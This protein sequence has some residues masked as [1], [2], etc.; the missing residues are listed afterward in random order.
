[1]S[2]SH[3]RIKGMLDAINATG[4]S[5]QGYKRLAYTKEE[6]EVF[7]LVAK[8]CEY[9]GMKIRSDMAGN[10]IARLEGEEKDVPAIAMGSHL[11]TVYTGGAFDGT[12]GVVA[13]VEVV[14]RIRE[15]KA[16][17]RHPL[18]VI[19]FRAEESSRFGMA[20]IG[21]K[22]MAGKLDIETFRGL[23]DRDGIGVHEAVRHKGIVIERMNEAKRTEK[24]LAAFFEVH[25][26]QGP[27]L[28]AQRVS[29]AIATAVAA[30]VRLQVEIFGTYAHSGTTAMHRRQDAMA[31][32][33]EF[34]LTV[35]RAAKE[36]AHAG[37]VGTVGVLN[38][39]NGAMNVVPG[40]VSLKVDIRGIDQASIDRVVAVTENTAEE[41]MR[42][43]GVRI[44]SSVISSETP[45]PLSRSLN[46][47][48]EDVA[49][50]KAIRYLSIPS[51]AGHDAMNLAA[52]TES[53]LL[54]IP[55]KDGLSH[56]P[57]EH[58]DIEDMV[59]ACDVLEEAVTI[60]AGIQEKEMNER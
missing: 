27:E 34:V 20:T 35:E 32:A 30:P 31:A 53:A 24:D 9:Q 37:T 36:E 55:S 12:V 14:T 4:R 49:T 3:K 28:E 57:D 38:V 56:H 46:T 59:T 5:S 7:T 42:D 43:R 58:S 33:A 26:E 2:R 11:D 51:G 6:D 45:V 18:E 16:K 25:I 1:M 39:N 23:T 19:V 44:D 13:A 22:A 47:L 21:S 15:S 48:L 50:A 41:I 10:L 8:W 54:F 29:L 52:F 40:H 60:R 17:L